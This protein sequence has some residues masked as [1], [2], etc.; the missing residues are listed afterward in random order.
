MLLG[1]VDDA[2]AATALVLG[3]DGLGGPAPQL[4]SAPDPEE[5]P[6]AK[7]GM[8]ELAFLAAQ[9]QHALLHDAGLA[10]N[11]TTA[12]HTQIEN[13]FAHGVLPSA[14]LDELDQFLLKKIGMLTHCGFEHQMRLY[15]PLQHKGECAGGAGQCEQQGQEGQQEEEAEEAGGVQVSKELMCAMRVH[16]LNETETHVFCPADSRAWSDN[17]HDVV[18]AN[19]TAIS[20]RNEEAVLTALRGSL[21]SLLGGYP[22]TLAADEALLAQP[23]LGRVRRAAVQLRSREKALLHGGLLFLDRHEQA[24]LDG[25]LSFQL[26]GAAAERQESQQREAAHAVFLD[27]VRRRAGDTR[28][29]ADV[30]VDLGGDKKANLTLRAGQDIS[31]VLA[32]FMQAHGVPA[33]FDGALRTALLQAVPQPPPLELLLGVVTPLGERHVLALAQGANATVETGVFCAKY[34]I[35]RRQQCADVEERARLL[36]GRPSDNAPAQ[37]PFE[38]RLLLTVPIDAPDSRR[39]LLQVWEGE[40]H[41]LPQLCADFFEHYQLDASQAGALANLAEQRLPPALLRIPVQ[42][43]GRRA[44]SLRLAQ[45]DNVTA[46]VEAFCHVL[47]LGEGEQDLKTAILK[48]ARYGMAPGT[49]LL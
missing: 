32:S 16:L 48:R 28:P 26:E 15:Y 11:A 9:N 21:T 7:R 10:P 27:T 45:G 41:T 33:S 14:G 37:L 3:P 24:L 44:V 8:E 29:L 40:Q 39:L 20:R 43:G 18:F 6:E 42:L 19:F 36:L 49:F 13:F 38:R 22:T 35:T 25:R 4:Y 30:S 34:N 46:V 12:V 5:D 31:A 17:C 47:E 2:A 23:G 1:E